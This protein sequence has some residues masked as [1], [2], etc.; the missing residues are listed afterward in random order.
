MRKTSLGLIAAAGLAVVALAPTSASAHGFPHWG[1]HWGPGWGFG[2]VY[3]DTGYSGCYQRQ[4]VQTRYGM[5]WR[6]ADV[7]GYG[8]Y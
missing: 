5:R 1:H 8:Y 4:L 3:V 6:T 7:C 2:G